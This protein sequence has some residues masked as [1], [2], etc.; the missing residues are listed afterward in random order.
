MKSGFTFRGNPEIF[1]QC[2]A[3]NVIHYQI[4]IAVVPIMKKIDDARQTRM[5]QFDQ[6]LRLILNG[7]L[8][9][10]FRQSLLHRPLLPGQLQIFGQIYTA[11]APFADDAVNDVT[12]T[13]YIPMHQFAR[14]IHLNALSSDL[15]AQ[16]KKE[17]T[18][19]YH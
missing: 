7:A 2:H 19:P 18:P 15:Q 9:T 17:S 1:L 11:H 16:Q 13:Q 4:G 10:R 8:H 5:A 14:L 6:K 12:L 3:L